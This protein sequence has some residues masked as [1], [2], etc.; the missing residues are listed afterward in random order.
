[1]S[2]SWTTGPAGCAAEQR[3]ALR[4]YPLMTDP[5]VLVR[6]ARHWAADSA[7]RCRC[8]RLRDEPWLAPPAA[9][10]PGG[11]W[12]GC[13]P[14]PA[15]SR[16]A[17]GV[18]GPGHDPEP[19]GARHRHRVAAAADAGGRRGPGW[20]SASCPDQPGRDLYAVAR[21]PALRRRRPRPTVRARRR[22]RVARRRQR[23]AQAARSR[24]PPPPA[25]QRGPRHDRPRRDQASRSIGQVMQRGPPRPRPSSLPRTVITS[26]PFSRR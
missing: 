1:M 12:T 10:R 26:M 20:R 17:L 14:R 21:E 25:D 7:S 5:L 3:G 13:W 18:R 2:R 22:W 9:S 6:A 15:A 16:G 24:R 4:F 8:S 19:G 11:R 23:A